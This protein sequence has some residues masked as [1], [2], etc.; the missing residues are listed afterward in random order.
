MKQIAAA[1]VK[2][3]MNFEKA[4]KSS[5]N[6]HFRSKYAALDVCLDAVKD[7]LNNEGIFLTQITH[8]CTDGVTVETMLIHVSG[9]FFSG[10]KLHVPAAKQDPQGYGSALTYCRRYSLLAACGIAPEDDDGNA[11]SKPVSKPATA[12]ATQTNSDDRQELIDLCYKAADGDHDLAATIL[13]VCSIFTGKDGVEHFIN[14]NTIKKATDKHVEA[15]LRNFRKK[16]ESGD[17]AAIVEDYHQ[18]R[19]M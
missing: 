18:G 11:A 8:D 5:D 10:G 2:A 3:Q 15:S 9:E 7:A 4:R 17:I 14:P 6:P 16:S 19:A 1:L 13:K 12:P